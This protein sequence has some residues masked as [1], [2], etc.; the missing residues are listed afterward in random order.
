MLDIQYIREHK[1]QVQKAAGDKGVAVDVAELLALDERRRAL[2]STIDEWERQRN[3][4]AR[5]KRAGERRDARGRELKGQLKIAQEEFTTVLARYR[6]LLEDIPNLPADDVPIGMGEA[7]N[8][9][10]RINGEIRQFAFTPKEHWELGKQLAILDTELAARVAGSRFVYVKGELVWLHFALIQFALS[11]LC[12]RDVLAGIIVKNNLSVPAHP[13]MPVLPPVFIR[14]EFL[15]RM[16]RLKPI[17]ERYYLPQDDL[18]LVGSAE[19]TLG[20]LHQG[21]NL[22]E[23][24]LPMR[25]AGYSTCFRREAGSHGK[26]VHGM[27]RVHQFDKLEIES[28][29]VREQ[30]AAEQDFIVAIQEHLMQQLRLPHRVVLVA[31]GEM[32]APDRRQIDIETWL[33]GQGRWRE[34][35]TADLIGDYQARR[36]QT[37]V[38]R[39]DGAA[40]YVHM[41]DATV[42]A[43]GRT[44]IAIMENYQQADGSIVVPL[45]LRSYVPFICI[46]PKKPV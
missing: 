9:V 43:I 27:L 7:A 46:G 2:Q 33:P 28:F 4:L 20:P 41:N 36:L 8:K 10:L 25:Y 23:E 26:D 15:R 44:L 30:A 3:A 45:A 16:A 21:M 17:E 32:G 42:F 34:T 31:S 1:D 12:N 18:Y 6:E 13:F 5:E 39:A 38:K 22:S 19:H 24:A 35:H 29:S 37:K 11:V 40:E 14:P